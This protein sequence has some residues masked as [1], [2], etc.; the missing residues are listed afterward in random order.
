MSD[1]IAQKFGDGITE[2]ANVIAEDETMARRRRM[3]GVAV[4]PLE[5]NGHSSAESKSITMDV[6]R[7][8]I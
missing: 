8:G 6:V 4:S 7:F 1:R 2:L 5:L 3:D